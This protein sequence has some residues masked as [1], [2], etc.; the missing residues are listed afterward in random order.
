MEVSPE[1]MARVCKGE[2]A[3]EITVELYSRFSVPL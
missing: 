3:E 1:R 2:V